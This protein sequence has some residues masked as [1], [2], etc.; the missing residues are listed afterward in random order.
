MKPYSKKVI[1]L[2]SAFAIAALFI[3]S[4]QKSSVNSNSDQPR[5]QLRLTDNPIVG[6]KEVWVDIKQVEIIVGDSSSPVIL[7]GVHAGV[8][9]LLELTGGKD[10]LLADALIPSGTISQIRLILGDN[11]YIITPAGEK[12]SLKTPALRVKSATSPGSFRWIIVSV[13]A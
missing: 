8:Y 9:N 12:I 5:L 6:V 4:C 11:N 10:T 7:S 13:N 2:F 3:F 1:Q